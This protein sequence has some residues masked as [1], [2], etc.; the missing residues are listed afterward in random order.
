M[1]QKA[2]SYTG[3]HAWNLLPEALKQSKA[4]G[5]FKKKLNMQIIRKYE[6]I[7]WSFRIITMPFVQICMHFSD[8]KQAFSVPYFPL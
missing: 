2:A 1:C 5:G 4:F 3:P 6:K 7:L 8:K